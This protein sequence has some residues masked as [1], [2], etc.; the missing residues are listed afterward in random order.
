MGQ[1]PGRLARL[2]HESQPSKS[3]FRRFTPRGAFS[4]GMKTCTVNWR[5]DSSSAASW[6]S[7]FEP[8][9]AKRPLFDIP[10]FS[11][12]V[13]IVSDSKPSALAWSTAAER[14]RARVSSPLVEGRIAMAEAA[15]MRA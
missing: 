10:V 3:A 5:A 11:A 4:A 15:F 14:I 6:S 1:P 8:K 7:S 2:G 9:C 13:P 12:S